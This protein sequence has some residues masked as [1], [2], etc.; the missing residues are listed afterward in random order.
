[1]KNLTL[2]IVSH[3]NIDETHLLVDSLICT[4]Y[5]CIAKIVITIN[6]L[7]DISESNFEKYPFNFKFIKNKS[8]KGF[9][10]NHNKAFKFLLLR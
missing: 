9:G 10:E 7:E 5:K 4:Y 3:K 1:M 6:K 2:S 8:F